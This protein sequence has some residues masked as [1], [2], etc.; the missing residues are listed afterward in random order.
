MRAFSLIRVANALF[1]FQKKV[2]TRRRRAPDGDELGLNMYDYGA[3]NYDPALGR[4]MNIDP[5]AEMSRRFSPYT[6][7]LNNP[8]YF[9][10][11]DGMM[12]APNRGSGKYDDFGGK[13]DPI[14]LF[15]GQND[16]EKG[17]YREDDPDHPPSD[18]YVNNLNYEPNYIS[19]ESGGPGKGKGGKGDKPK[20]KKKK[21][22]NNKAPMISKLH[23]MFDVI[24]EVGGDIE[25]AGVV[26]A[27][28]TE[29]LSL[30][31][32]PIGFWHSAVGTTGNIMLDMYE[33]YTG[34]DGKLK[35]AAFRATKF[36]I[37]FGT[38]K[39]IERIP[40]GDFMIDKT[41]LKI[42]TFIYDK[43]VTPRV[44]SKLKI[45]N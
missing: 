22:D 17:K 16:R 25:I 4:W 7:A 23:K 33:A 1:S 37:T 40:G 19:A 41:V 24:E 27:P 38:G 44:Q 9:I 8:V 32:E 15:P 2:G 10:D 36:T 21:S 45:K 14:E 28:A 20:K 26:A 12:Q 5:L 42:N 11:P 30:A 31:L 18:D 3:R 6:Y 13:K 34:V 43:I 29:G 39:A 35:S